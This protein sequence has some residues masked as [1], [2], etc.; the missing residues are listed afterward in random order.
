VKRDVLAALWVVALLLASVGVLVYQGIAIA[1]AYQM[2]RLERP[3]PARGRSYPSLSVVVAARNEELDLPRCLDGLLAQDYPGLEIVTVDGG[4]TDRTR[5]EALARA[6]RVRLIE[7]PPL[8]DGWVGKNWACDE[9]FRAASGDWILFTDA[10]MV[11]DPTVVRAAFEWGEGENADLV[12]LAPRMTMVGRWER[13]VMP[14]YIQMVLTYFRTPHVNRDGSRAAMANGQF[15]LVR[16]T[17]YERVGGHRAIRGAVL[18]DV[19]LA[20]EF[21]R[22]GLRLRVA[23][24]PDLL[25]TRMYRDRHEMFEGLLKTIHGTRFSAVRQLGFLA[26][27]VVF[28]WLPLALLPLAVWWGSVPLAGMG[29]FLW[30]AL[31]GKHAAF[32][33]GVGASA[34]DGLLF[35]VAIGFYAVVVVLSIV[36][37]L[38]RAPL[39]WKGRSYP[40]DG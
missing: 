40:L 23:Y 9:G 15:T 39:V 13:I 4:S 20:Q 24:A 26:G 34:A 33:H 14:M 8:P 10:D 18:E 37:G 5:E 11:Y 38:R 6:P 16:R 28:F 17:A 7:E 30:V 1:L 31:F 36:R 25:S 19:R 2:P 35:P 22:S 29:A 32:S 3:A 21:R 12:T 27:L